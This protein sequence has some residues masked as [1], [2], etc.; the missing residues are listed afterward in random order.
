M[1]SAIEEERR[2]LR[3]EARRQLE[4]A[5]DEEKK[6]HAIEA[7]RLVDEAV[8]EEKKFLLKKL[9][10]A[11]EEERKLSDKKLEAALEQVCISS[12]FSSFFTFTFSR[13]SGY[14]SIEGWKS[15]WKSE[16]SSKRS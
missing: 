4:A 8:E 13:R 16:K 1:E 5:L 12:C 7:Q 3:V 15:N 2:V 6:A 9:E 14:P 11:L 10:N